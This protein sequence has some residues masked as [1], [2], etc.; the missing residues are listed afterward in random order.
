[1]KI[2]TSDLRFST[3]GGPLTQT[4]HLQLTKYWLTVKT[5]MQTT[6]A[7]IMKCRVNKS[8]ILMKKTYPSNTFDWQVWTDVLK[9]LIVKDKVFYCI[10]KIHNVHDV[11]LNKRQGKVTIQIRLSWSME[12]NT[13]LKHLKL[14]GVHKG[15]NR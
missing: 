10:Q 13:V 6:F 9:I 4:S 8:V 5:Y 1:M 15:P 11:L 2:I 3:A 14:L 7:K 12:A